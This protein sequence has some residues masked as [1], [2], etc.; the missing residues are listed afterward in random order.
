[1]TIFT[2]SAAWTSVPTKKR[3]SNS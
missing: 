3:F 1:M 2:R